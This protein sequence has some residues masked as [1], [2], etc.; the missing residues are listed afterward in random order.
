MIIYCIAFWC[1]IQEVCE[2]Y[3]L[4]PIYNG[5]FYCFRISHQFRHLFICLF[6]HVFVWLCIDIFVFIYLQ[7]LD[8]QRV[9]GPSSSHTRQV[10]ILLGISPE[11]WKDCFVYLTCLSVCLILFCQPFYSLSSTE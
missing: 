6:I 9:D 5:T 1:I 11:I 7:C 4:F 10:R 2:G 3:N 8:S